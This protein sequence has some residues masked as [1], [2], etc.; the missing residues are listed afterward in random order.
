MADIFCLVRGSQSAARR[1][2][3]ALKSRAIHGLVYTMAAQWRSAHRMAML[4]WFPV[5]N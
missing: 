5:S 1:H 3:L 2:S 4:T